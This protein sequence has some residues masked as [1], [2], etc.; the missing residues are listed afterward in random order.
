MNKT[1]WQICVVLVI[2][3]AILSYFFVFDTHKSEPEF[4]KMPYTFW[5]G[6]LLTTLLVVITFIAQ[7]YSPFKDDKEV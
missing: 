2:T 7:I 6:I 4:M 3:I 5:M 1:I